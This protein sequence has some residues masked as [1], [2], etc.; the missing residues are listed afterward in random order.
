MEK[1]SITLPTE[2]VDV[3]NAEI[4]AGAFAS[5]SEVIRAAM[6]AWMRQE[7]E[8]KERIAAIRAR[9]QESLDDPR[10]SLSLEEI[11]DWLETLAVEPSRQ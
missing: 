2:M 9:V 7:E 1:L 3:I 6:R 10:P 8:H 4:D 5:T 11:D